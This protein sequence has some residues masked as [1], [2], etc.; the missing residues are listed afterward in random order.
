[1]ALVFAVSSRLYPL[2]ALGVAACS[3]LCLVG[4]D[5]EPPEVVEVSWS[6]DPAW[7]YDS[8]VVE[9]D[10]PVGAY[11][12]LWLRDGDGNYLDVRR[13]FGLGSTARRIQARPDVTPVREL[14]LVLDSN[15]CD[16]NGNC[17][18]QP[19]EHYLGEFGAWTTDV[20]VR[21][22][23]PNPGPP[24]IVTVGDEDDLSVL[25]EGLTVAVTQA[26]DVESDFD[27]RR[28][29][30]IRVRDNHGWTDSSWPRRVA[31]EPS[32]TES[33]TNIAMA[34]Q[35]P[36]SEEELVRLDG[37]PSGWW[38]PLP[39]PELS[40]RPVLAVTQDQGMVVA[41]LDGQRIHAR[42]APSD[43]LAWLELP[44]I[45]VEAAVS[46]I[47]VAVID[48]E[49]FLLAYHVGGELHMAEGRSGKWTTWPSIEVP[50]LEGELAAV[51]H[52]GR[53]FVAWTEVS[54]LVPTAKIA[55]V[56]ATGTSPVPEPTAGSGG[57]RGPQL[58]IDAGSRLVCAWTSIVEGGAV[59]HVARLVDGVW[60][61][62]GEPWSTAA[63]TTVA[64]LALWND[65]LPVLAWQDGD[66]AG[67]A[68]YNGPFD[69]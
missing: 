22:S 32:V 45:P 39:P 15:T 38:R 14:W 68:L 18:D 59:G 37:W 23:G 25:A 53:V 48:A 67:Y 7:F 56:S 35:D 26:Y 3:G 4:C 6:S 62:F 8:V 16:T 63:E 13:T 30:G 55:E 69:E 46:D 12:S 1:M 40:G 58:A 36:D 2:I 27:P 49:S 41:S 43:S 19:Y 33:G 31:G 54:G 64:S 50:S 9:F 65:R 24:T 11:N 5:G 20:D 10:E 57:S 28:E 51:S 29:L 60:V 17:I 47:A 66:H 61:S 21:S 42:H 52:A 34:F 44:V